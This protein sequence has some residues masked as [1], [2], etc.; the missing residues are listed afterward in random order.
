MV[1]TSPPVR[2]AEAFLPH[3]AIPVGK[4]KTTVMVIVWK[5]DPDTGIQRLR[6]HIDI[7][8]STDSRP[9][10][11]NRPKRQFRIRGKLDR[12][13]AANGRSTDQHLG[14]HVLEEFWIP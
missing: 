1:L 3:Q 9:K 11:K 5:D 12:V 2:R 7:M 14:I 6:C 13:R 4:I 10:G 8:R